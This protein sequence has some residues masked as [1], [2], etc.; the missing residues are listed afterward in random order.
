MCCGIAEVRIYDK[1]SLKD[2]HKLCIIYIIF[3]PG[4]DKE[5]W[6][7]S[8]GD[9]VSDKNIPYLSKFLTLLVKGES[10]SMSYRLAVLLVQNFHGMSLSL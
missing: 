1:K 3:S 10:Y 7:S 2:C 5:V 8:E 9:W 6:D 4:P